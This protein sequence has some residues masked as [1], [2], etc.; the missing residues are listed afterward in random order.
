MR[1]DEG[2]WLRVGAAVGIWRLEQ[3]LGGA[4]GWE[5]AE[6]AGLSQIDGER[7]HAGAERHSGRNWG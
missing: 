5:V 7:A 6:G 2:L 4:G 3:H 1:K